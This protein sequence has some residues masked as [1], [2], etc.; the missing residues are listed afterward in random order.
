MSRT[1]VL[2]LFAEMCYCDKWDIIL[3]SLLLPSLYY[4]SLHLP[5]SVGVSLKLRGE[6]LPN[7]SFVDVDDIMY[8]GPSG[9]TDLPSNRNPRDE[10]LKCVT[11]LVDCCGTES[12]STI[13]RTVRGNWYPDVVTLGNGGGQFRV[14]RGPNEVIDGAQV[15]GSVRLYRFFTPPQ[16]GRYCCELPNA[17]DPSVNQMLCAI[18]CKFNT[19]LL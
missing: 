2:L 18:I 11:D 4:Y 5:L 9:F 17:A 16:R 10:A 1:L 13:T 3:S 7:D 19:Q 15:Y 6:L 8:T 12:G 14:N